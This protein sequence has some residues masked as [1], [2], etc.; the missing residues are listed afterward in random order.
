MKVFLTGGTGFIGQPLAKL[1]LARGWGVTALVRKAASP[2]AQILSKMGAQLAQGDVTDHDSMRVAMN[3]CDIVIH[4]AGHYELGVGDAGMQRMQ[5]INVQGTENVLNLALE[6]NIPRSIYVST[7][8]AFGHTGSQQRDETFIR[9]TPFHS[10]YE[11]TKADAHHIAIQYQAQGLPLIIVCPNGVI[12]PND[13]SIFGYF[14]R[15]YLNKLLPPVAWS[16]ESIFSLVEVNDVAQGIVLAAVNGRTHETYILAGE[17]LSTREMFL[18]WA[19]KPGRFVV[20]FWLPPWL[21]AFLLWMME[22]LQRALGLP[23]FMS[24]ETV[25]ASKD[26]LNY[27]SAKARQ[28]LGWTYQTAQEMWFK[29]IDKEIELQARRNKRGL[30]SRLHPIGEKS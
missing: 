6:L 8:W 28:E 20:R 29:T 22:P 3:G 1:L 15:L 9:N 12:G 7:L 14:L 21:A 26:S 25:W 23:A 2:Q 30:P 16:P 4:N 13:H 27:S 18:L 10:E 24:R 5:A 11:R 17:P 19:Q